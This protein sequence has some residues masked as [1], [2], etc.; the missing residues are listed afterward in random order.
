MPT[1]A[2]RR[3]PDCFF[4]PEERNEACSRIAEE[5]LYRRRRTEPT[6]GVCLRQP[7]AFAWGSHAAIMPEISSDKFRQNHCKARVDMAKTLCCYPH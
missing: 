2:R 6:E 5:T 4:L 7:A 1:R 3:K